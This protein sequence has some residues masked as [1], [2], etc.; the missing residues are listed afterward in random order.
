M[1]LTRGV[2]V[3][4]RL[5]RQGGGGVGERQSLGTSGDLPQPSVLRSKN[6]LVRGVQVCNPIPT[7][8]KQEDR[9]E[10]QVILGY[11]V[12]PTII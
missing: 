6:I 3:T 11:M 7:R 1:P 4:S 10:F 12:V 9:Y 8:L 5:A 2:A